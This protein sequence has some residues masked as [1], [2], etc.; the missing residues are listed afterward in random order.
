M[1]SHWNLPMHP[2]IAIVCATLLQNPSAGD[3]PSAIAKPFDVRGVGL[4]YWLDLEQSTPFDA[5]LEGWKS[6]LPE[7][8]VEEADGVARIRWIMGKD[9]PY[10]LLRNLWIDTKRG[11]TPTR[12]E[13]RGR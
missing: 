4:I 13:F 12:H 5:V 3:P 9:Q 7:G 11:F 2:L 6:N 10:I 1:F 8:V